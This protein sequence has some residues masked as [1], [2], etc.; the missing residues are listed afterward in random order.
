MKTSRMQVF[1]TVTADFSRVCS[2]IVGSR[3]E[4]VGNALQIKVCHVPWR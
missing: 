1:A 3:A 2:F 4:R